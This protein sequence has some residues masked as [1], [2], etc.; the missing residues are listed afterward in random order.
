MPKGYPQENMPGDHEAHNHHLAQIIRSHWGQIE[1]QAR[2]AQP[3]REDQSVPL[4][5]MIN[6]HP[7]HNHV[8]SLQLGM[9]RLTMFDGGPR[10]SMP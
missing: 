2:W 10:L 1:H 3:P 6:Y 4:Q 5:G 7:S 8:Q 9:T